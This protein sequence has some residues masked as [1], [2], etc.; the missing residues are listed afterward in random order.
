MTLAGYPKYVGGGILVLAS[1]PATKFLTSYYMASS[2]EMG[3]T[4]GPFDSL[5]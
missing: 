4:I 3:S 5:V 1:K 2:T